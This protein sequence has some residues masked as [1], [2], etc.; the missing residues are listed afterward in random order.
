MIK[1]YV[2]LLIAACFAVSVHANQGVMNTNK[3]FLRFETPFQTASAERVSLFNTEDIRQKRRGDHA[4]AFEIVVFGGRNT[5]SDNAAAYY[6]PNGSSSVTFQSNN[7]YNSDGSN[8]LI[9]YAYIAQQNQAG[10]ITRA[11]M[12]T[13]TNN[14]GYVGFD[15]LATVAGVAGIPAEVPGVPLVLTN[16]TNA[17]IEIPLANALGYGTIYGADPFP[18]ATGQ[19]ITNNDGTLLSSQ[20]NFAVQVGTGDYLPYNLRNLNALVN[21]DAY[22]GYIDVDTNQDNTIVMPWNFGI[23]VDGALSPINHSQYTDFTSTISPELI[24]SQ[25]G[26]GACWKQLLSEKDTGCWI[27]LSTALQ[28][29]KMEMQLNETIPATVPLVANAPLSWTTQGFDTVL[30]PQNVTEA[31]AQL[32]WNYGIV[33][34]AQKVTRLADIELKLG[35]QFLC[36][37]NAMANMFVGMVIPTG[38]KATAIYMAEPIAGNGFHFGLMSGATSEVQLNSGADT[39]WSLRSDLGFRYLFKNEQVRSFDVIN[40]GDWSRYMYVWENYQQMYDA[41]DLGGL[42]PGQLRNY[43]PGINV[44]TQ[45]VYVTPQAQVRFNQAVV[46]ET[47]SFKGE[48]GWNILARQGEKVSLVN[49]WADNSIAFVDASNAIDSNGYTYSMFN[50]NRTI[51]NDAYQSAP[52]PN[53]VSLEVAAYNAATISA[54]DL[55]LESAASQAALINTPYLV[56]GYAFNE[57]KSSVLSFGGSYETCAT[58]AYIT[59]WSLWGKF[60]LTF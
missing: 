11:T 14:I 10:G 46:L 55:N 53:E 33:D 24:R 22:I 50:M 32:A 40:R 57:E 60:G 21:D 26:F 4:G 29:V 43:T 51:Y 20:N 49:D 13:G 48:F 44:F 23:G 52:A 38:N 34:G 12:N 9:R 8:R 2:S 41:N 7:Q 39:R 42:T 6:M 31:F 3:T 19:T 25:W 18:I 59:N 36:E 56:V 17:A 16:A 15:N 37:D 45:S 30:S 58:N 54:S 47:G 35:Y 28:Q 5:N 27:E 1:K